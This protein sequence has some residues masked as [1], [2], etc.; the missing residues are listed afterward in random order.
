MFAVAA[1][2]GEVAPKLL[3]VRLCRGVVCW[4]NKEKESWRPP[5]DG[6]A[7]AACGP[8]GQGVALIGPAGGRPLGT[9][10]AVASRVAHGEGADGEGFPPAILLGG[11]PTRDWRG[12]VVA[13]KRPRHL[14]SRRAAAHADVCGH[15][16]RPGGAHGE[17]EAEQPRQANQREAVGSVR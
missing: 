1:N 10:P 17:E 15:R 9:T 16:D 4:S 2:T 7:H 13:V 12:S 6:E 11:S 14:V 5:I 8:V 3:T